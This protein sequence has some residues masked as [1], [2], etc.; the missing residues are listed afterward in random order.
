LGNFAFD[1]T[2]H[3]GTNWMQSETAAA[4]L[5]FDEDGLQAAELRP[6]LYDT[7]PE[8]NPRFLDPSEPAFDDVHRFLSELSAMEDTELGVDGDMIRVPLPDEGDA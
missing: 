6:A 5:M 8:D 3:W 7:G 2:P 4:G 1:R